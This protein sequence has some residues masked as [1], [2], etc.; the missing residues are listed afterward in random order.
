MIVMWLVMLLSGSVLELRDGSVE[1]YL[2]LVAEFATSIVL[3]AGGVLGLMRRWR[4]H[5]VLLVGLGM[6]VYTVIVSPG[7]YADLGEFTFVIMFAIVFVLTIA[8]I[9]ITLRRA[10]PRS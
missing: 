3:I 10:R 1:I 6:L 2:H 5:S 9:V 8:A 7:Y 4:G